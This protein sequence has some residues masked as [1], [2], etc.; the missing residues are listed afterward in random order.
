[1][2]H[3]SQVPPQCVRNIHSAIIGRRLVMPVG[4]AG[5]QD[6]QLL[7]QFRRGLEQR[8]LISIVQFPEKTLVLGNFLPAF[9]LLRFLLLLLL[10]DLVSPLGSDP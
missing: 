10:D 5:R 4:D 8:P 9:R 1:M 3:V 2:F 6:I 7:A